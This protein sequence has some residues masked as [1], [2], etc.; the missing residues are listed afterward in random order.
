MTKRE[1]LARL[2]TTGMIEGKGRRGEQREKLLNG[3]T[4][5]LKIIM[6]SD[7]N[8]KM[9]RDRDTWK[10]MIAWAKEHDA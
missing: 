2:V 9:T 6:E 8:T 1:K 10:V 7:R 4:K 3:P 5:W